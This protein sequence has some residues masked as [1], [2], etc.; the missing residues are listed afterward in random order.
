MLGLEGGRDRTDQPGVDGQAVSRRRL[1]HPRLEGIGQAERRA[2]GARVV[3][4]DGCGRP[5]VG[6]GFGV[7]LGHDELDVASA[8]PHVDRSGCEVAG[9]LA[10]R[11]RQDVEQHEPRRGIQSGGEPLGDGAGV[12]RAVLRGIH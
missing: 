2:R 5:L 8:Q 7:R 6:V 9:D 12:L 10:G 4:V 3:E 11:G 1:V